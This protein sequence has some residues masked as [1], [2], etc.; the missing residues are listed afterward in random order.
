MEYY[1][2]NLFDNNQQ[3]LGDDYAIV[4]NL[5]SSIKQNPKEATHLL[6]NFQNHIDYQEKLSTYCDLIKNHIFL[7]IRAQQF[8]LFNALIEKIKEFH[9]KDFDQGGNEICEKYLQCAFFQAY[10]KIFSNKITNFADILVKLEKNTELEEYLNNK[11]S[12][13]K[14]YEKFLDITRREKV[15]EVLHFIQIL[16]AKDNPIN[17][18]E[19]QNEIEYKQIDCESDSIFDIENCVEIIYS[20]RKKDDDFNKETITNLLNEMIENNESGNLKKALDTFLENNCHYRVTENNYFP[21]LETYNKD[22]VL[23]CI[24]IKKHEIEESEKPAVQYEDGKIKVNGNGNNCLIISCL[25]LTIK[26]EK[27]NL[28]DFLKKNENVF[29]KTKENE[30][31]YLELKN[32][33]KE[34]LIEFA[35]TKNNRDNLFGKLVNV[36]RKDMLK[37]EHQDKIEMIAIPELAKILDVKIQCQDTQK[38]LAPDKNEANFANKV[39]DDLLLMLSAPHGRDL[40][41]IQFTNNH[42]IKKIL[43]GS[44]DNLGEK[45]ATR[46]FL[47]VANAANSKITEQELE[48]GDKNRILDQ[49]IIELKE[50]GELLPFHYKETIAIEHDR[51]TEHFSIPNDPILQKEDDDEAN[52]ENDE[53]IPISIP[54]SEMNKNNLSHLQ[55]NN[56]NVENQ[57][58]SMVQQDSWEQ[59][60]AYCSNFY[61]YISCNGR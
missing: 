21:S 2:Y 38:Q 39:K 18:S 53:V 36:I 11:E 3:Q 49:L 9:Q 35:K 14:L 34:D 26:N 24:T 60:K 8:D 47:G 50:K 61:N 22:K 46:L 42:I 31:L 32:S 7:S 45:L 33:R 58:R 54:K 59:L 6:Q 28:T 44:E 40:M 1:D 5:L 17:R 29:N 37:I 23:E 27:F 57:P 15:T 16:Q 25:L 55:V 12:I 48:S 43:N 30:S 13:N 4:S 10:C 56:A 19:E 52:I 41:D 51:N 20:C